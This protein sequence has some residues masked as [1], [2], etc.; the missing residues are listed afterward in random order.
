MTKE[1]IQA[2]INAKIAG[3]GSAVDVG[4]ALPSILS[5]ILDLASAAPSI[6]D[7]VV[8]DATLTNGALTVSATD[9]SDILAAIADGNYDIRV[10]FAEGAVTYAHLLQSYSTSGNN[11]VLVYHYY[12]TQSDAWARATLT[13]SGGK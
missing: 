10:T 2:L 1:Q 8:V 4:G 12:D 5:E 7:P 9:K 6:P 13:F 3:Q 11:T